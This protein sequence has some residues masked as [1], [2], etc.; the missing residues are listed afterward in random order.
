[1]VLLMLP[2]LAC[3]CSMLEGLPELLPETGPPSG[4]ATPV[5]TP[6][7]APAATSA[8]LARPTFPAITLDELRRNAGKQFDPKLAKTFIELVERGEIE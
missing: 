2:L 5:V 4:E 1:L 6:P 3:N 8:P 7:T